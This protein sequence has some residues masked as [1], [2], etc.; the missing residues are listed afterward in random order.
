MFFSSTAI[1][2]T[3][4]DTVSVTS[5]GRLLFEMNQTKVFSKVLLMKSSKNDFIFSPVFYLITSLMKAPKNFEKIPIL[6]I[7]QL[8]SFWGVK[9]HFGDTPEIMH[10][11]A[12]HFL[13]LP[14]LPL[15]LI[16]FLTKC[17]L[18][19]IYLDDIL[20]IFWDHKL[21]TR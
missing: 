19:C 17:S 16:I 18:Y 20:I 11:Q 8:V 3:V 6:K 12:W 7:W 5:R 21:S 15:Q 9:T 1:W 2:V 13:F 4:R 10:F 14:I